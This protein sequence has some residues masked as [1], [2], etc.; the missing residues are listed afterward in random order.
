MQAPP[1]EPAFLIS[2]SRGSGGPSETALRSCGK[3]CG[4]REYS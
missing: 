1:L 2:V 3:S 4:G